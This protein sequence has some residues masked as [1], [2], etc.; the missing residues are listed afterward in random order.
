[1]NA[2]GEIAK[3]TKRERLLMEREATDLEVMFGGLRGMNR[4]PDALF[5]VDP[6]QE[7]GAVAE[8]AQLNIPVIALLNSDCDRRT[9][10][11]PIPANDA[12]SQ[13]ITYV[14]DEVAKKYADNLGPEKPVVAAT[15]ETV[16]A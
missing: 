10:Q 4:L 13:V 6:R 2:T 11:Y 16:S 15:T 3:Y 9:I 5:I 8:A 14:V 1:M 7:A 12:A